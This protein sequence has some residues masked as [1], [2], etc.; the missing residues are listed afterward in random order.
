M[1]LVHTIMNISWQFHFSLQ[2]TFPILSNIHKNVINILSLAIFSGFFGIKNVNY[3]IVQWKMLH[4]V[5]LFCSAFYIFIESAEDW[6]V[7]PNPHITVFSSSPPLSFF[8]WTTMPLL[9]SCLCLS[10]IICLI[11]LISGVYINIPVV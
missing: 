1:L 7:C 8:A 2:L 10:H 5:C 3:C 4:I 11:V 6:L 9:L